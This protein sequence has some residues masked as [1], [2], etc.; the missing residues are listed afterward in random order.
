MPPRNKPPPT[1]PSSPPLNTAPHPTLHLPTPHISHHSNI[2]F[3]PFSRQATLAVA[4]PARAYLSST[5]PTLYRAPPHSAPHPTPHLSR[6]AARHHAAPPRPTHFTPHRHH[7]PTTQPTSN[8]RRCLPR[9]GLPIFHP[10]YSLPP[11]HTFHTTPT[12]HSNHSADKQRLPLLAPP[13]LSHTLPIHRLPYA[14]PPRRKTTPP[15]PPH[16]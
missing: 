5:P 16:R 1:S 12:S 14:T 9:Q 13:G 15:Q 7:I 3:Q 10:A 8:A 11:P 2:T 6:T 4:C